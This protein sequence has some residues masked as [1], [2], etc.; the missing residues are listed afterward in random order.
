MFLYDKDSNIHCKK[1]DDNENP[2][3]KSDTIKYGVLTIVAKTR[4]KSV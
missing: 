4:N 3:E 1:S 2:T